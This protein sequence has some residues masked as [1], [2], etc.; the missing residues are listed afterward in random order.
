MASPDEGLAAIRGIQ[1]KSMQSAPPA[2]HAAA[3]A[4]Q[5]RVRMALRMY[6]HPMYTFTPSPEGGFPAF[7]SGELYYSVEKRFAGS[8]VI[9]RAY[10]GP[11]A[12]YAHV[13]EYG[14]EGITPRTHEY[15][16]WFSEGQFWFRK[17]VDV[18]ARP[19]MRPVRDAMIADGSLREA[20]MGGFREWM[21]M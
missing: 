17:E 18:P 14:K 1:L 9:G 15:M 11:N 20:F 21:G 10:V 8:G 4:F 13:Q 7:V 19:F 6:T 5:D 12:P 16:R 3:D 2:V